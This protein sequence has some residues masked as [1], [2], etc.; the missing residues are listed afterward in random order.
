MFLSKYL[1]LAIIFSIVLA[2][3]TDLNGAMLNA[4]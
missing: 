4:G 1:M 3:L 2:I